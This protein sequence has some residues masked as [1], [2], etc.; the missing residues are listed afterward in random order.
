MFQNSLCL[1]AV[2]F[3]SSFYCFSILAL[4]WLVINICQMLAA[5]GSL[6]T[7]SVCKEYKKIAL[8]TRN[9]TTEGKDKTN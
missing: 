3:K 1:S 5:T 2:H 7:H 6:S 4:S 8:A 9:D